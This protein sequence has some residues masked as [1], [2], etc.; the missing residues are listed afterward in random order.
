[1]LTRS[2]R[3]AIAAVLGLL[4]LTSC[5]THPQPASGGDHATSAAG[6]MFPVTV[7]PPGGKP[8]TLHQ[9]PERIVSLSAA[10][11]E[12]LFAVGAGKQVVAVDRQSNYPARAPHT[13]LD[14][15]HPSPEAIAGYHPDLV[16]ASDD[17]GNLVANLHKI[18]IPVLLVPA[19]TTLDQAYAEWRV[20]GK[21][22]GHPKR[23]EQLANQAKETIAKTVAS[24]PKPDHPLS[25]YHELGPKLYTVTSRTFVGQIYGLFGLRNIADAADSASASGYPQLSAEQVLRADPQLIFLADSKCCGQ[26]AKT[27]AARPGWDTIAAV[28]HGNVIKLNDDIASRWGPRIVDMVK[29]VGAA[30]TRAEHRE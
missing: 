9:R 6:T 13:R 29:A 18:D 28:Q 20:L 19:A 30:I 25:Y 27:I 22:T 15:F 3:A 24:T 2:L 23:A 14:A 10:D 7:T 1:M 8:L 11:T 16:V 26:D 12:I 4:L 17:I 21:A 5:A